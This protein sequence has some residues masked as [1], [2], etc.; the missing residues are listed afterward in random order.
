LCRCYFKKG[1]AELLLVFRRP[2]QSGLDSMVILPQDCFE[3][4]RPTQENYQAVLQLN[5]KGIACVKQY[6]GVDDFQVKRVKRHIIGRNRQDC[7]CRIPKVVIKI[8]GKRHYHTVLPEFILPYCRHVLANVVAANDKL[9]SHVLDDNLKV[10]DY[11]WLVSLRCDRHDMFA[12]LRRRYLNFLAR[13]RLSFGIL[14][15]FMSALVLVP[16]PGF[17]Y[18]DKFYFHDLHGRPLRPLSAV[19]DSLWLAA[20]P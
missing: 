11:D 6:F 20:S 17:N 15:R 14:S 8:D 7:L 16:V 1:A 12:Y 18:I 13:I 5:D 10:T 19:E 9:Q 3:I 4:T 2:K